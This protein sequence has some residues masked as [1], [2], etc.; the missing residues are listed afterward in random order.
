[1]ETERFSHF[2]SRV[3]AT[4]TLELDCSHVQS[5]LPALVE[6]ELAAADVGAVGAAMHTHFHQ[7][8]D[9]EASYQALAHV[10]T[11]AAEGG[12]PTDETAPDG[13]PERM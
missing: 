9:C 4:E 12:L 11:V 7:C 5:Y 2:I 8:P 6:A 1:M 3:F 10:A 13:W